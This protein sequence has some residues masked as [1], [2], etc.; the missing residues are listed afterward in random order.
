MQAFGRLVHVNEAIR[1]RLLQQS[2][3]GHENAGLGPAHGVHHER[4]VGRRQGVD[5]PDQAE[6]HGAVLVAPVRAED[7]A[8]LHRPGL[9]V[10]PQ[11]K[12]FCL[13]AGEKALLRW[14]EDD[15]AVTSLHRGP[16]HRVVRLR[17]ARQHHGRL[18]LLLPD[19]APEALACGLLGMLGEHE[20]GESAVAGQPA[21]V[22]I[23]RAL[24]ARHRLQAHAVPVQ[25][26]SVEAL[27][28]NTGI[29]V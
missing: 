29:N 5:D 17:D 28:D 9:V 15:V 11:A 21:R 7:E 8:Y 27:Q 26:D 18:D 22:D 10:Q 23:V 4:W 16:E 2:G 19:E 20:L 3:E 14:G 13:K 1:C 25:R 24:H 6:H 12:V